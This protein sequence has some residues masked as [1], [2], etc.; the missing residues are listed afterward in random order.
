MNAH[1]TGTAIN[2]LSEGT[3]VTRMFGKTCL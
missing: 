3:A 1:G 2:D